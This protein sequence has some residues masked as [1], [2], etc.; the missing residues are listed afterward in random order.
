[1]SQYSA[2]GVQKMNQGADFRG[3]AALKSRESGGVAE[4]VVVF[5]ELD[6]AR[7]TLEALLNVEIQNRQQADIT[8]TQA[9]QSAVNNLTSQVNA[10][11]QG[12]RKRFAVGGRVT[13]LADAAGAIA[14]VDEQATDYH[15][16]FL[17]DGSN[18]NENGVYRKVNGVP[19]RVP[20]YAVAADLPA[21]VLVFV[22]S[23]NALYSTKNDAVTVEDGIEVEF[24]PIGRI[25]E[26]QTDPNGFMEIVAG[27][28]NSRLD[29][30]YF[31]V[32][33]GQLTLTDAALQT[34]ADQT[35]LD[36]EIQA[37]VDGDAALQQSLVDVSATIATHS[38]ALSD[39]DQFK[40]DTV[41]IVEAISQAM[42]ELKKVEEPGSE[43]IVVVAD[44]GMMISTVYVPGWGS[45]K[46]YI[47][48]AIEEAVT[49][50]QRYSSPQIEYMPGGALPVD[51]IEL[52]RTLYYA[53]LTFYRDAPVEPGSLLVYLDRYTSSQ[54][55][56]TG[57]T[58]TYNDL[59]IAGS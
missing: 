2:P 26:L 56:A 46:D 5:S 33:N 15:S 47:V 28:L 51:L 36:A 19:V 49:P 11:L 48:A 22:D 16:W 12:V 59:L 34:K 37:R 8:D 35:A 25:N 10:A 17:V 9:W 39:L 50:N 6:D 32:I 53:K 27:Q 43:A 4:N 31:A 52:D 57:M 44:G 20:E 14:G 45:E 54:V 18:P 7:L 3:T 24:V 41:S 58:Q 40:A 42:A 30:Q 55:I 29:E 38:Q 21:G 1:M 13:S 23:E